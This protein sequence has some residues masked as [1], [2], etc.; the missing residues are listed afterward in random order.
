MAM[1]CAGMGYLF[2]RR[3]EKC[4]RLG[5]KM[6]LNPRGMPGG[7]VLRGISCL[8]PPGMPG[9]VRQHCS[10]RELGHFYGR[11]CGRGSGIRAVVAVVVVAGCVFI[12]SLQL[13]R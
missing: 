10:A 3:K 2:L 9:A 6:V 5:G 1:F 7:N 4:S 13:L 11:N 8:S 12:S